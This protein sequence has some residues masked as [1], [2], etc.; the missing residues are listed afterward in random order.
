MAGMEEK[1]ENLAEKLVPHAT[2]RGIELLWDFARA[3]LMAALVAAWQWFVNHWDIVLIIIVFVASFGILLW[4]DF[5]GRR[6]GE[7][8]KSGVTEAEIEIFNLRK[9]LIEMGQQLGA[10]KQQKEAVKMGTR[11]SA[12]GLTLHAIE[13]EAISPGLNYPRKL[14][15]YL[16]NDGDDV[17]LGI[18][19]WIPEGIDIQGGKQ[20]SCQ[21]ELKEHLGRWAGESPTKVVASGR[22][23]RLYV[24][25]DSTVAENKVQQMKASHELGVLQIPARVAG[26]VDVVLKIRP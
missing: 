26:I 25:I 14:R 13:V 8:Q 17:E 12:I 16:S 11:Q 10:M 20:P 6:N 7:T 15:M 3:A 4:R 2:W 5:S 9:N 24:G 22:W 18:G 1:P 23:V 21:Y 19:K